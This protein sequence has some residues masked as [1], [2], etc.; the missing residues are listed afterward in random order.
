[1]LIMV[2]H[3]VAGSRNV[4]EPILVFQHTYHHVLS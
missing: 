1:M 3:N 2:N 4:P